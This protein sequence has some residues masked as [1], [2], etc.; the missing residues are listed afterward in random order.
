MKILLLF[1]LIVFNFVYAHNESSEASSIDQ[2]NNEDKLKML[3]YTSLSLTIVFIIS[4]GIICFIAIS[5]YLF[6]RH[7]KKD[8]QYNSIA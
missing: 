1:L 7:H 3:F 2:Q 6:K 5:F 8:S 4:I